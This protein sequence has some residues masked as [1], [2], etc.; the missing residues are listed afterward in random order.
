[1]T[2]CEGVRIVQHKVAQHRHEHET[3]CLI[4][5]YMWNAYFLKEGLLTGQPRL[6]RDQPR[7]INILTRPLDRMHRVSGAYLGVSGDFPAYL[8]AYLRLFS[9]CF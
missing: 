2:S 6:L 3:K 8:A 7:K 5:T 1:M 9:I 4:H